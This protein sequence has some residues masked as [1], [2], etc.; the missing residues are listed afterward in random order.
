MQLLPNNGVGWLIGGARGARQ[1]LRQLPFRFRRARGDATRSRKARRPRRSDQPLIAAET[2]ARPRLSTT[3]LHSA[4]HP[5]STLNMSSPAPRRSQRNS[6]SATPRR[7]Q[8]NSQIPL[9]SPTAANQ[10]LQSEASQAS[11]PRN[12]IQQQNI[13]TSSPLFY[14][15]S[16]P[17]G[18]SAAANG[19]ANGTDGDRTPRASAMNVGGETCGKRAENA[20]ILTLYRRRLVTHPL[21][22][23]QPHAR[24]QRAARTPQ[25]QQRPVCSILALR[26][27]RLVCTQQAKRRK[28]RHLRQLPRPPSLRR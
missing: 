22:Q 20:E 28:L 23:L 4:L 18:S 9:S 3:Y 1:D 27:A 24:R 6:A 21:F 15:G 17:A 19:P 11:T 5:P 12:R 14:N 16:T 7:S 13:P 8:R 26:P 25:C 10:Q 2:S